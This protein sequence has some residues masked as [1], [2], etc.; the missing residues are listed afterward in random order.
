MLNFPFGNLEPK[1][2]TPFGSNNSVLKTL[3]VV[4][5]KVEEKTEAKNGSTCYTYESPA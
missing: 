5:E 2:H 1:S 4:E 3:G